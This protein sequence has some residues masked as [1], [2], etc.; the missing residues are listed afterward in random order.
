MLSGSTAIGFTSVNVVCD[1]SALA[2]AID[3][4]EPV[5]AFP[6]DAVDV[7][8]IS[9]IIYVAIG[10]VVL[11][12]VAS[13]VFKK[14]VPTPPVEPARPVPPPRPVRLVAPA[15]ETAR[16]YPV[17]RQIEETASMRAMP[18]SIPMATPVGH[19]RLAMV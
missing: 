19:G 14:R 3:W 7:S 16:L 10:V 17:A 12:G 5:F 18:G 9:W 13:V 11:S 1:A 15:D 2:M 8:D 6:T 4:T